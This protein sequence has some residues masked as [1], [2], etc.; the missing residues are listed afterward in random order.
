MNFPPQTPAAVRTAVTAYVTRHKFVTVFTLCAIV[1]GA[2]YATLL[3]TVLAD[4]FVEMPLALR[5]SALALNLLINVFM[6]VA[7]VRVFLRREPPRAIAIRLDAALPQN[8]DRWATALELSSPDATATQP[9]SPELVARLLRDT[10]ASTTPAVATTVVPTRTLKLSGLFFALVLAA[11]A[12]VATSSHFNFRLLL[13]RFLKPWA[14]L[15]RDSTTQVHFLNIN[16]HTAENGRVPAAAW[17]ILE[18]DVFALSIALTNRSQ[19]TATAAPDPTPRLEIL[20]PDGR[21]ISQD[22][23]RAGRAWTFS[24]GALTDDVA[25]RIRAGDALTETFRVAVQPRIRITT[26][27]HTVRFPGY[28]RLAEIKA[29]PLKSDRLSLLEDA[30]IDF[31]VDCDQPI[32]ELVAQFELLDK[33]RGDDAPAAKSAREA[34]AAQRQFAFDGKP[35][36]KKSDAPRTRSLPVKIRQNNQATLRLKL[37]QPGLLRLRVT[38]ENGLTGIERVIVVEPVRDTPPRLTVSG[39]EPDTYIVPGETLAF[40]YTVEDDLGVSDLLMDWTVAGTARTGNLAGEEALAT[41]AAGQKQLTGQRLLQR[42]NYYV[43]GGS[44]MEITLIAVDSKGQEV[45]SPTFRIFLESDSF[46]TRFANGLTFLRSVQAQ[47]NQHA[48][49]VGGLFNQTKILE[50]AAG[51]SRTWPAAQSNLLARFLEQSATRPAPAQQLYV[52]QYHGGWPQRLLESTALAPSLR[53]ALVGHP[54]VPA[55]GPRLRDT[56]DLPAT[57]AETRALLTNQV[58]LASLWRAGIDAETR[59]FAP[60]TLLQ[61]L[62]GIRLRLAR[63]EAQTQKA[64]AEVQKANLEFYQNETKA[65]ITNA[66]GLDPLVAARFTND[67]AALEAALAAKD[68]APLLQRLTQFERALA[69]HAPPASDELQTA[70]AEIAQHARTNAPAKRQFLHALADLLT[71]RESEA[72]TA[73][74]DDLKLCRA[75]LTDTVPAPAALL[76]APAE[77]LDLWLL[78][79]R[80]LRDWRT[81]LLDVE[82]RRF[83]LQPDQQDDTDAGLREQALALA[84]RLA[85]GTNTAT[86]PAFPPA[87]AEALRAALQPA[88]TSDFIGPT[89]RAH[90]DRLAAVT[91]QLEPVARQQLQALQPQFA[92]DFALIGKK[93][94]TLA[95]A[96]DAH[97]AAVDAAYADF[98]RQPDLAGKHAAFFARFPIEAEELQSAPRLLEMSFRLVKFLRTLAAPDTSADWARTEP[99]HLLELLFMVS[100]QGGY[101]KVVFRYDTRYNI[102]TVQGYTTVGPVV[103]GFAAQLRVQAGLLQRAVTDQPL[104]FDFPRFLIENKLSGIPERTKAEFQIAAPLL[105]KTDAATRAAALADLKNA[106]NAALLAK[107]TAAQKAL[108]QAAQFAATDASRATPATLLPAL[109]SLQ[110]SLADDTGKS[111]VAELNDALAELEALPEARRT[112]TLPPAWTGRLAALRTAFESELNTRCTALRLPPVSTVSSVNRRDQTAVAK[113]FWTIR[114]G[115]DNFDRRWATRMRDTELM[116]LRKVHHAAAAPATDEAARADLALTT[117]VLGELR[118]RQFGRESRANKGINLLPEDTGPSLNL[119]PHIA[120]EFLRARTARPPAAFADRTETYFQKLFNDLKR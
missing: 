34:V 29:Q 64:N 21:L 83:A 68:T 102:R 86:T 53:R 17:R 89:G 108:A 76:T 95:E 11:L 101:D 15:P 40:Q 26:V 106:P 88:L 117:A 14:N 90:A 116:W 30:Q 2:G 18:N 93:L 42:M 75:W 114:T 1:G 119:P 77:P 36:E 50:A 96:Y 72:G 47:A 112:A 41:P 9:A 98:Q 33:S 6:I 4:R 94:L 39:L 63:S 74:L 37:D 8:Q 81:L 27:R 71:L 103:R 13:H 82:L 113:I 62:R 105:A 35:P 110:A 5:A 92:Q 109:K 97:A 7:V 46:A 31:E 65:I 23:L 3:L 87:L 19:T 120:Q 24:L 91:R 67:V 60:E 51:S 45:R 69:A 104:D 80:L 85:R 54:D 32:R 61:K 59:R 38:G 55:T 22:F 73:P 10:E 115:M 78:T 20:R 28:A 70:V 118:A 16:Q 111:T 25:F 99:W 44:P 107:E 100:G 84:D 58:R 52:E 48:G 57:L 66:R 43:Y 49:H 79:E 12:L 56:Q